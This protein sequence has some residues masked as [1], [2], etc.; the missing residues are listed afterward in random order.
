M[1]AI[2]VQGECPMGCGPA[3]NLNT[4]TGM[5]ICASLSCPRHTAVSELLVKPQV[6]HQVEVSS[7]GFAIKHPLFERIEDRLFECD[8][9]RW[10]EALDGPPVSA[11]TY[12]VQPVPETPV[13]ATGLTM[14]D[15]WLFTRI[16]AER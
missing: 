6:H 14:T 9:Q 10:L 1:S 16:E 2:K 4:E 5:I 12:R 11:G 15:G 13:T 3:L 7:G 8:L